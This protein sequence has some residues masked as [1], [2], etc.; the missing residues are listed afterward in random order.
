MD[1][2]SPTSFPNPAVYLN[3]LDPNTAFQ[4]EVTRNVHISTLGASHLSMIHMKTGSYFVS[5]SH[6][7]S[8]L[9]DLCSF[10][11]LALVLTFH[12]RLGT[13]SFITLSV[14]EY[15]QCCWLS[16]TILTSL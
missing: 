9:L 1:A 11:V 5:V 7:L 10:Q 16:I 13:L 3:Y 8:F 14:L 15:S 4:Y 12:C 6:N 2:G